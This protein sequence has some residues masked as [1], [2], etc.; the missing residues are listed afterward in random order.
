MRYLSILFLFPLF[1]SNCKKEPIQ[2]E[3]GNAELIFWLGK[4][5]SNY[6]LSRGINVIN[7]ELQGEDLGITLSSNA[8]P[9]QPDCSENVNF[10]ISF[11]NIT[12]QQLT[13]DYVFTDISGEVI[14]SGSVSLQK[15]IC[16]YVEISPSTLYKHPLIGVYEGVINSV[17]NLTIEYDN[18]NLSDVNDEFINDPATVEIR[19]TA[20]PDS[21]LIDLKFSVVDLGEAFS[22]N[23]YINS[24]SYLTALGSYLIKLSGSPLFNLDIV[25]DANLSGNTLEL[26]V[27]FTESNSLADVDGDF[28]FVGTK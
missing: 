3:E 22:Y 16:N 11:E 7:L 14:N 6:L 12:T 2:Q 24:D 8:W 28:E 17:S 4:D 19:K 5:F 10:K 18:T 1:F 20:H 9:E 26:N 13:Q 23:A 27:A 25:S 15:N 21:L